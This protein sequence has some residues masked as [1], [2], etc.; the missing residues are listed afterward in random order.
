[1]DYKLDPPDD[2]PEIPERYYEEAIKE[3]A[4]DVEKRAKAL[5]EDAKYQAANDR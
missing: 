3:G 2:P 4:F 5:W 1:M